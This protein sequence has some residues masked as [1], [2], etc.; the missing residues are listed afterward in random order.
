M[1]L[2]ALCGCVIAVL[3]IGFIVPAAAGKYVQQ[4]A[5]L[6]VSSLSVDS[7][8]SSG[9]RVRVRARAS[10][11]AG[12][13]KSWGVRTLG[14]MGTAVVGSM[15]V[16]DFDLHVRLP[17]YGHALLGT[18]QVPGMT[19]SIRN[20]DVNLLDFVANTQPGSLVAIRSLANDYMRGSLEALKVVGEADLTVRKGLLSFNLGA[21]AHEL[22]LKG[23]FIWPGLEGVGGG[24]T[25]GKAIF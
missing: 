15:R 10:I 22:V 6:N 20:G 5:V 14:R 11:D 4:A 18:A 17:A 8:T 23:E 24:A 2:T 19:V 16:K 13:V 9:I 7:F 25:I 21:I 3:A 1:A 12:R